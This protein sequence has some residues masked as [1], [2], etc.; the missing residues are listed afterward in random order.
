MSKKQARGKL[1]HRVLLWAT[2]G[3]LG[4]L[5]VLSMVGAFLGTER[6]Q[7][8]FN[9]PMVAGYWVVLALLLVVGLGAFA[10][11]L[12]R[13]GLLAMHAGAVL[14]LAGAMA[15]S[16]GGHRLLDHWRAEAKLP[17]GM[18][19]I[20]EGVRDNRLFDPQTG[21]LIGQLPFEVGLADFWMEYYETEPV[22]GVVLENGTQV[23]VPGRAGS[24]LPLPEPLPDVAVVR[25]FRSFKMVLSPER[26]VMDEPTGPANPALELRLTYPDGTEKTRYVFEQ[27]GGHA[28]QDS[29]LQFT[30]DS[31]RGRM[32]RD[33]FS[34]LVVLAGEGEEAGS[35]E[36]V[37]TE[38]V[39][40]VN[41]PLHY[42]GYHFY[43]SSYSKVRVQEQ[44]EAGAEEEIWYTELQVVSDTGWS[45]VLAGYVVLLAGVFWHC[46]LRHA[47]RHL[48]T[49]GARR[50]AQQASAASA[51]AASSEAL[52]C[53]MA[54]DRVGSDEV[55]NFSEST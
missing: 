19:R 47:W 31:G 18:M 2:L 27:F 48:G 29:G 14:V 53:G 11:L 35:E 37:L 1:V 34:D 46:W 39:I 12:R 17:V 23:S 24:G 30:F 9:W 28:A 15:G 7:A 43:Q 13:W 3:A 54:P 25:V 44:G 26:Q 55:G 21:K 6:A 51:G 10:A 41:D 38:K 20:P 45:A 52:S 5:I 8:L 33:Y 49:L 16:E 32:V 4:V 42:G 36:G 40:E 50:A 22:L